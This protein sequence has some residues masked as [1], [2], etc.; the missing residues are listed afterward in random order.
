MKK[1]LFFILLLVTSSF[2]ISWS[3]ISAVIDN[4][5][6]LPSAKHEVSAYGYNFRQYT[7]IDPAGRICTTAM[8]DGKA[9]GLDCEFPPNQEIFLEIQKKLKK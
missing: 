3:Q 4:S 6:V 8:S 7:W 1:I 5:P 2:A 9:L